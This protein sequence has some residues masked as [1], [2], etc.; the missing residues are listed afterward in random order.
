MWWPGMLTALLYFLKHVERLYNH[1]EGKL[2]APK[3]GDLYVSEYALRHLTGI[4]DEELNILAEQFYALRT[5]TFEQ[6]I[7][8]VRSGRII[9]NAV[10]L[11]LRVPQGHSIIPEE[12]RKGGTAGTT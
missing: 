12:L 4:S 11:V 6:F 3:V 8:S 10:E 9:I 5:M 2:M 7:E 1:T